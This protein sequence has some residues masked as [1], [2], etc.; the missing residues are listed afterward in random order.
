MDSTKQKKRQ[1]LKIIISEA[2]MVLAVIITVTVLALVVSGYW[3][4]S[5]FEV[6]RQGMLQIYSTPTGANV[7]IDGET[8]SWLQRTNTSKVLSSGD[9]T[10][11]LSKEG[12]DTWSKTVNIKEG[13]LYKL[14]YPRL[15]PLERSAQKMLSTTGTTYAFMPASHDSIL[16]V[17]NTTKW[18]YI[19]LNSDKIE[20]KTLDI[21]NYFSNVSLAD[22]HSTGLFG[23]KILSAN[24]DFDA[25]HILFKATNADQIEWVL[26]DVKNIDKSINLSKEFGGNFSDIEILDNSASNLLVVQNGNLHKIDI[27]GRLISA[28][29][30]E[31][32]ISFDHFNNEVVFSA[33][34]LSQES[35]ETNK[36]YVG[37]F[38]VGDSSI[39]KLTKLS[40]PVQVLLSKFYD[41]KYITI[42]D[43]TQVTVYEKDDFQKSNQYEL[44]FEPKQ[45][46]VGRDGEFIIMSD[47]AKIAT[48]DMEANT[49]REWETEGNTFGWIDN[50]MIYSVK[51]GELIVYDFDGLNRRV[52]AKNVSSH[53]PTGITDNKWLYYFSDDELIRESISD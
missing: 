1:S 35:T 8:S 32:V 22:N 45:L 42:L 3:I 43:K 52:I 4:N 31:N 24:W 18:Q 36:Y 6:E 40:H 44:G 46:E 39:T 9:H 50:D 17:N 34:S 2:I 29:L 14:H 53:F 16:L 21:S 11:T 33:R 27:S 26:I 12:Y 20:P 30:V 49:I 47:G 41:K 38:K 51:D 5:D 25:S 28:V 7:T 23:G 37:Y 48:I 10:V 19:N 15:F 13:L